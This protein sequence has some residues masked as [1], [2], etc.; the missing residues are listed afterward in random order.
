MNDGGYLL[1]GRYGA[2]LYS[3]GSSVLIKLDS[4]G[5]ISWFKLYDTQPFYYPKSLIASQEGG[6]LFVATTA[7]YRCIVQVDQNGDVQK[8]LT[9]DTLWTRYSE[10]PGYNTS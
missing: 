9:L 1:A 3:L 8:V 5:N 4:L 6:F 7:G 10:M 2:D